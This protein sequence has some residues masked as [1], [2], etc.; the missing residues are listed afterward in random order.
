MD[1]IG[2]EDLPRDTRQRL[3]A[4]YKKYPICL[5]YGYNKHETDP[6]EDDEHYWNAVEGQLENYEE[7]KEEK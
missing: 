6:E 7:E 5:R 2:L 3:N 4:Y 1:I